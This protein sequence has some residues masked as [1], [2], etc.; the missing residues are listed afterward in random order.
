LSERIARPAIRLAAGLPDGNNNG[1]AVLAKH[2][3]AKDPDD[4]YAVV[5]V[6]A[7]DQIHSLENDSDV[8]V[9]KIRAIEFP[10]DQAAVQEILESCRAGRVGEL[11][12]PDEDSEEWDEL[13]RHRRMLADWAGEQGLSSVELGER[14]AHVM[15]DQDG[16]ASQAPVSRLREFL[17][18][19]GA[20][21][22]PRRETADA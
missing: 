2:F 1:A 4:R 6:G 9:L 18:N 11:Q 5:R 7:T 17:L 8:A 21:P 13:E 12:F 20:L 10:D 14:W 22:D 16:P 19:L 3:L 15:G